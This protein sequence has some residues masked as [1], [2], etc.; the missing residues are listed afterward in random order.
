LVEAA[1]II[2][3]SVG[4]NDKPTN[5]IA[6]CPNHHWAM[7][8]HLIAPCPDSKRRQGVWRASARLDDRLHGQRELAALAGR[9]VI[10][11]GEGKF[12]PAEEGLRWREEK[13]A[14]VG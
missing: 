6:L 11:P 2:P 13:L 1:H 12:F 4:W 8:H 9:P 14:E 10:P 7:D 3:F 5:G